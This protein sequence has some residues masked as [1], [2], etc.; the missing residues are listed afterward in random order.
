[1]NIDKDSWHYWVVTRFENGP[2]FTMPKTL[3]QYM[4]AL[5]FNS[6]FLVGVYLLIAGTIW[7]TIS[8][9]GLIGVALY[10]GFPVLELVPVISRDVPDLP[11]ALLVPWF[12]THAFLTGAII[13]VGIVTSAILLIGLPYFYVQ[14]ALKPIPKGHNPTLLQQ[15]VRDIHAKTCTMIEYK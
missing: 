10:N 1:M 2:S 12:L 13:L 15:W 8:T 3:C 6:I 4:T 14:D 7:G 11:S 5:V 9:V